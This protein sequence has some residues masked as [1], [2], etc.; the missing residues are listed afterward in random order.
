MVEIEESKK[1]MY[2]IVGAIYEVRN[3]LGIGLNESC[4]QEALEMQLKEMNV[5]YEREL[6]F[7][8]LYHGKKMSASFRID[9]LCKKDIIVEC[10]AVTFLSE[11][12]RAQLYNYMRLLRINHGILVNFAP[13]CL[14]LE[15]YLYDDENNE[16]F[17]MFGKPIGL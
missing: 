2:D 11:N 8:P 6:S 4:Y 9:F 13:K 14:E 3:E 16:I 10:K 12:H 1:F 15:R 7:H 5:S 17:N